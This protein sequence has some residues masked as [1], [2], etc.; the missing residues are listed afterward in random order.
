MKKLT[1]PL[2]AFSLFQFSLAQTTEAPSVEN[3][4]G[5]RILAIDGFAKTAD[6][7]RIYASTE[8]ANSVFYT[9][10][11]TAAVDVNSFKKW[12]VMPT[13]SYA[14]NL[15][16]ISNMAVHQTSGRLFYVV[17]E[18]LYSTDASASVN[19]TEDSM[20]IRK[21]AIV[22]NTIFYI[23]DNE[24]IYGVLDS[25]GAIASSNKVSIP[26]ST[27][28]QYI[29]MNPVNNLIYLF[30]EETGTS[31]KLYKSSDVHNAFTTSTTFTDI[32]PS[33]LTASNDWRACGI[34]PSG[35]IFIGGHSTPEP[36]S[37]YIAYTDDE[38]AW[39]EYNT[40]ENG[41]SGDNIHFSGNSTSY[42][43]Y[44]SKLYNTNKGE[45]GSWSEFGKPG[46]LETH[47]ND[48]AVYA[49]PNNT[50]LVIMTTDQGIGA[51][52]DGGST[53]FEI[54][55]GIEAVQVN[56]FSMTV[57]KNT[58]WLASKSGVRMVTNYTTSPIWSNA[59]F[60]NG[61]GSPY[62]SADLVPGT[63]TSAY[64]GNTRIYK[65]TNS[66]GNWTKVFTPE[67]APYNWL[68]IGYRFEAITVCPWDTNLILAGAYIEG[69]DKGGLF[70]SYDGGANWQQQ[71]LTVS[72][73]S[74]DADVWD[75]IF[76]KEGTTTYAY[77]GVEYNSGGQ[78]SIYKLT[79]DG[80]SSF[81]SV[82]QDMDGST[83]SVGY[84]IS[85]TIKDLY[86]DATNN[87]IYASGTD[88]GVNHPIAYYKDVDGT[89]LWTPFT[90][91]GFPV[92]QD[93]IGHAITRGK[94]TIY[95]AVD[96]EIYFYDL[97]GSSWYLGYSYPVGTKINVIFYDELLVGTGTGLYGHQDF[98]TLG[99]SE[100]A[101]S[102]ENAVAKAYPNPVQDV[103]HI[104]TG[105]DIMTAVRIYDLM[106]ALVKESNPSGN[107]T[108]IDVSSLNQ[109]TYIVV[110]NNKKGAFK[111]LKIMKE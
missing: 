23:K 53:I 72:S 50:N 56:D 19:T 40:G 41:V 69:S 108:S 99:S 44:F 96:H 47:P 60:P 3:V 102:D 15:G 97:S 6:S 21:V 86:V 111:H 18:N 24:I 71:Y 109:G 77:V 74:N 87:I 9:D 42:A 25:S 28:L 65:T 39:T 66:G 37:K 2:I 35:R 8:S 76:H 104:D 43:V 14:Q 58:A 64:V 107:S 98:N 79:W 33:T 32:T 10:Y 68:G 70:Y 22:G 94:D 100:F 20:L 27:G 105:D 1:L 80:T 62:Y 101:I 88:V 95:V 83:T 78:R 45:S 85:A 103:L 12:T 49:D 38:M 4:Y 29:L 5:G 30:Y 26:A 84:A 48:G 59:M 61:D 34:S 110:I 36:A 91:T 51:S 82:T 13:L 93:K 31:L 75:I 57:D 90:V 81:S 11:K 16:Y 67:D 89:N 63:P 52:I 106:G 73:G 7:T 17:N 46:G 55:N 54:N 92:V